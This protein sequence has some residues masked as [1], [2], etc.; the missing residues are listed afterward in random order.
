MGCNEI[1]IKFGA[2]ITCKDHIMKKFI[3][4]FCL[5]AIFATFATMGNARSYVAPSDTVKVNP[6]ILVAPSDTIAVKPQA[7][8]VSSDTFIVN[9]HTY[10]ETFDTN[11]LGWTEF[12][13]TFRYNSAVIKDGVMT[14]KSSGIHEN[15]SIIMTAL[16]GQESQVGEVTSFET[17]CYA[18][19]EVRLPFEVVSNV[20]IDKLAGDRACGFILNYRDSGNF[21]LFTLTDEMVKFSRFEN[22]C[23][24]GSIMQSVKWPKK[25]KVTQQWKLVSE[26]DVLSF[27]VDGKEI[28]KVRYMP[29]Y[30]SGIGFY[31][32][33][34]QK[35]V[36]DDVTFTQLVPNQEQKSQIEKIVPV[37]E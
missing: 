1:I 22:G 17:H 35:L 32:F 9:P 27:N 21:Y 28:M 25:K 18:P 5:T 14:L 8:S 3:L 29:V 11:S 20:K 6:Q 33:G 16:T 7:C 36:I 15:A 2:E 13:Y 34:E 4:S 19:L 23:M 30:F 12:I 26:G 37:L 31:T 10:V 24:Q